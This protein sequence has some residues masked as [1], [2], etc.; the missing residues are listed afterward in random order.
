MGL[1]PVGGCGG[2][3]VAVASRPGRRRPVG[4]A[5]ACQLVGVRQRAGAGGRWLGY[6]PAC[7]YAGGQRP[8]AGQ[9]RLGVWAG[10]AAHL[11]VGGAAGVPRGLY[12]RA[13]CW[14]AVSGRGRPPSPWPGHRPGSGSAAPRPAGLAGWP[15]SGGVDRRC[16]TRRPRSTSN[17]A[18]APSSRS[19]LRRPSV[20]TAQT[21][22]WSITSWIANQASG[23][24]SVPWRR[25]WRPNCSWERSQMARAVAPLPG[26]AAAVQSTGDP[27]SLPASPPAP[28][29]RR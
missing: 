3:P 6:G 22:W 24:P 13:G 26:G 20:Q 18:R 15:G 7:F 11:A 16:G 19:Q 9:V 21:T 4:T 8:A 27:P 25:C 2:C 1:S 12:R 5:A 17:R 14:S 23:P 28:I 10:V 29:S